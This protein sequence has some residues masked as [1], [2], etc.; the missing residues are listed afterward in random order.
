VITS[1]NKR[2]GAAAAAL[3]AVIALLL[4][5]P[6][7]R[8]SFYPS[9]PIYL[10]LHVQCPGCGTTRALSALVHGHLTEA[11]HLNPLTTLLLPLALLYA[12][13]HLWKQRRSIQTLTVPNPPRYAVYALLVIATVF[14]IA[15]NLPS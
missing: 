13:H 8:Y 6:P 14:T 12:T 11:L 1:F 4:R 2:L 3:S 10:Y 7:D 15:R 5:F 9:C